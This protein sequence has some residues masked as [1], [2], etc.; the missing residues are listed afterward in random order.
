M[1]LKF[2]FELW[3]YF[4]IGQRWWLHSSEDT[5]K[6][7][8]LYTLTGNF[9]VSELH[10]KGK[11]SEMASLAKTHPTPGPQSHRFLP[12]WV[13]PHGCALNC[14]SWGGQRLPPNFQGLCALGTI[15]SSESAKVSPQQFSP[16]PGVS[17]PS[18]YP[19][20]R[21]SSMVSSPSPHLSFKRWRSSQIAQENLLCCL[22]T[23]VLTW[24]LL[25]SYLRCYHQRNKPDRSWFK[26]QFQE[27]SK[28]R[29]W[30][31]AEF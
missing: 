9:L 30:Y 6:L 17:L 20:S 3:K 31:S 14:P 10:L 5:L 1:G 19:P 15:T 29:A 23:S 13:G 4:R 11:K 25:C 28:E 16:P 12:V 8:D 18:P 24:I 21:T 2:L 7:T 27:M 26:R 22:A